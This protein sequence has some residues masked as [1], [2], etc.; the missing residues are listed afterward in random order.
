MMISGTVRLRR[1]PDRWHSP[2][3]RSAHSLSLA[4]FRISETMTPLV[5]SRCSCTSGCTFPTPRTML[6]V[7]FVAVTIT[8]F[9]RV[10]THCSY[11]AGTIRAKSTSP[12]GLALRSKFFTRT[13]S[14]VGDTNPGSSGPGVI[15]FT[16]RDSKDNRTSTAFCSYLAMLYET[17]SS[18]MPFLIKIHVGQR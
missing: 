9:E 12:V 7:V 3:F 15:S 16:P 8:I 13:S 4:F 17:G 10:L 14:T 18:L 11:G 2:P 6:R 5:L 1:T